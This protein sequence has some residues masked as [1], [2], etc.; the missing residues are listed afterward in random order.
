MTEHAFA[1]FVRTL[2]R[3]KRARR[4]LTREEARDAMQAILDGQV[5][6]IQ[7]GAFL[8]LLRVKEETPEELAGFL[9]ACRPV[10]Y[11]ALESLPDV[12]L[13]WPS[14]AGKKKHHP[15]YLLAALLLANQGIRTLLHG[16]P[17]HTPNRVYSDQLLPQLGLAVANSPQEAAAHLDQHGLAYLPLET[18]CA[19]L[20]RL[21]TLRY[22]LGLRSPINTLAR[23]LNPSR[24]PLSMQSVFHPAYIELHQGAADLAG[25]QDLLLFKGEGGELEIRP[26]ARTQI[27]GI[28]HGEHLEGAA[29]LDNVMPRQSPPG[30]PDAQTVLAVWRGEQSDNYGENAVIQTVAVALW[31]LDRA[32][33]LDEAQGQARELWQKRHKQ[34]LK[35]N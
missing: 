15:W 8:M 7:L 26:D 11:Q 19:P 14:Y 24:A 21:L 29:V 34:V 12:H 33:S 25:D 30:E 31:G 20:S 6:D 32:A 5:E 2:G 23:S 22:F 3:G 4:S 27:T 16:G 28:R 10:C 35:G 17:A 18:F 1:P 13:D 9:D